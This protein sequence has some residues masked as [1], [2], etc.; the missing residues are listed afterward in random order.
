MQSNEQFNYMLANT[1]LVQTWPISTVCKLTVTL[2]P[3]H[4][5]PTQH[6]NGYVLPYFQMQ[7]VDE[8]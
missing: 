8:S 4:V 7:S 3:L 6:L 2:F 1:T 5:A